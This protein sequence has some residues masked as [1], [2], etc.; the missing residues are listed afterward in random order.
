MPF[1]THTAHVLG[2]ESGFLAAVQTPDGESTM[3]AL[4]DTLFLDVALAV[5]EGQILVLGPNGL[6]ILD[7]SLP[8]PEEYVEVDNPYIHLA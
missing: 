7:A 1:N 4:R 2:S 6:E 3:E 8:L 5:K